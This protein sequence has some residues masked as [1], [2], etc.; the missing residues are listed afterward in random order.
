MRKHAYIQAAM[1][2]EAIEKYIRDVGSLPTDREGLQALISRPDDL[3]AE[4]KWHGP[5]LDRR[6]LPLDPW[7]KQFHYEVIDLVGGGFRIWSSGPDGV[8]ET[9]DDVS[10]L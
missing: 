4:I 8:S 5:Y 2:T 6:E 10:S 9:P 7:A 3:P 1:L